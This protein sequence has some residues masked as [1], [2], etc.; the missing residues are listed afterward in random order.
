MLDADVVISKG[1]GNFYTTQGL[2]RDAFYL[3]LSKGVTAERSTG[4]I[5]N[6]DLVVD[7]LIL[8]YVPSGTRLEGTLKQFCT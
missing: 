7:G 6:P 4:V 8:A 3:M 2:K 1:Q 5:A